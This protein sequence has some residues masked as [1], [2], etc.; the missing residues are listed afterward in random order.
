VDYLCLRFKRT[1]L[2][3]IDFYLMTTSISENI[4]AFLMQ[5]NSN[6]LAN[7]GATCYINTI[8][9]CLGYCPTF[10]KYILF[11]KR[12]KNTPTP[13]A[14]ELQELYRDLWINKNTIA[15]HGFL[16]GL[17][18]SLGSYIDIFSQNDACEFLILYLDKLNADLGIELLVDLDEVNE[19]TEKVQ[20]IADPVFRRFTVDMKKSWLKSIRREYSA[21]TEIFYGQHI[22]QIICGNCNYLHH[23][24]E[25]YCNLSVSIKKRQCTLE[26]CL[27]NFFGDETINH[28]SHDWKCDKCN[29]SAPSKKTIKLWKI[30]QVLI[31]SLKRFN[32]NLHKNTHTV[33]VPLE[34]DLSSHCLH[35][36]GYK[37]KLVA[38]VNHMGG[39]G[40]GHYNCMCKHPNG[41]WYAI[42]DEM[43]HV[44]Q[45]HELE[46]VLNNG[47]IYFYEC[48]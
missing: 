36:D 13:L 32:H 23:N 24:H 34:L 40:S 48:I 25:T 14:T 5:S 7:L 16:K 9:Q 18:R 20:H 12:L 47:Y 1:I 37:Y 42:D 41:V 10:L 43:V 19:M 4:D 2:Q 6:G 8:I 35:S 46:Y 17:H 30:P 29:V 45:P 22:S 11:G 31:V 3:T 44:A 21:L 38:V 26:E 28:S 33:T 15:P 39:M 27:D